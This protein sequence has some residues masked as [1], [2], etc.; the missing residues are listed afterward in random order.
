MISSDSRRK[1][2]NVRIP[3]D[4]H[5]KIESSGKGK[6]DIVIAALELYFDSKDVSKDVSSM[7][8]NDSKGDSK[9]GTNDSGEHIAGDSNDDS[10][11][12]TNDSKMLAA[13]QAEIDHLRAQNVELIKLVSQA[14]TLHLQTQRLLPAGDQPAPG[15]PVS[16]H[17]PEVKKWWQVWK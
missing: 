14:Q 15:Q 5:D 12:L 17:A 16:R 8:A 2:L 4:L 10:K 11:Q 1:Q 3:S 6:Q 7:L 13:F 9:Q